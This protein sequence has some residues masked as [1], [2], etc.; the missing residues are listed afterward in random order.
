MIECLISE[1]I[2]FQCAIQLA[3]SSGARLGEIVALKFSDFDYERCKVTFERS[4]YKVK[5][6]PIGLKP[7]KDNDVRTVTIYPEVIELVKLLHEERQREAQELGTAW[8]GGDW[9]FTKWD[10]SIMHP[11]TPSQQFAKFLK[12]HDL[13]H[14]KFHSLRHTSATLLL[15]SRVNIRQV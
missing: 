6:K 9:L 3:I 8:Q 13:T 4:A 7:P 2:E 11:Q 12:R 1:P 10:G 15:Y 5:S 14:H